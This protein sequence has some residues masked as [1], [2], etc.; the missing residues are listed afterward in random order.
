MQVSAQSIKFF[1][2]P[3]AAYP[4]RRTPTGC[5]EVFSSHAPTASQVEKDGDVSKFVPVLSATCGRW[6]IFRPSIFFAEH[7]TKLHLSGSKAGKFLAV[8]ALRDFMNCFFVLS[9]DVVCSPSLLLG[10]CC[11]SYSY[12]LTFVTFM[13]CL[14]EQATQ[15]KQRNFSCSETQILLTHEWT[16]FGGLL[17]ETQEP[18]AAAFCGS[19]RHIKY[20]DWFQTEFPKELQQ[21]KHLKLPWIR[22][23][24]KNASYDCVFMKELTSKPLR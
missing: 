22:G 7:C 20:Q 10:L 11:A 14:T 24:V 18:S 23:S 2:P 9:M 8:S 16:F 6:Y 4:D 19:D 21:Q 12:T 17:L 13:S 15:T 1:L 5:F 3:V